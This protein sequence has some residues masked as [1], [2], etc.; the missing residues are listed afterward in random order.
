MVVNT[1]VN[2]V[3]LP[4]ADYAL[5]LLITLSVTGFSLIAEQASSSAAHENT[6]YGIF[7]LCLFLI[8]DALT[9]NTEKWVYNKD[10]TFTP[11]QMMFS[12]GCVTLVYSALCTAMEPG[13]FGA[14]FSFIHRHPECIPEII[15]LSVNS[16]CGQ[17][18]IYY[19]VR[20]HGPVLL[21]IMM[22]VRQIISVYISAVLYQHYIPLESAAF[23]AF[24]FA[25]C[26]YKPLKK[27][28]SGAKG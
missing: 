10:R 2:Q 16:T 5:A 20:K 1:A 23:A 21:S 12:M 9:S 8:C 4:G 3:V 24:T 27:W 26:L 7:L 19:T 18:V 22:T 17:Y 11:T 14:V 28:T 13:G 15:M 25:L 6:M